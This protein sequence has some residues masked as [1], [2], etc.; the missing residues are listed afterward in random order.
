M[1]YPTLNYNAH[2]RIS[3]LFQRKVL[4]KSNRKKSNPR[5]SRANDSLTVWISVGVRGPG[6]CVEDAV[7]PVSEIDSIGGD[8]QTN[9]QS[10]AAKFHS[11]VPDQQ[12]N[13][14]RGKKGERK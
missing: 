11:E 8:K 6:S 4:S 10:N 13:S 9:M 3:I 14:T 12:T 7:V 1:C 5:K 2:P